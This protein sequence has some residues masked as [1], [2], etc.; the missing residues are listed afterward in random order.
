MNFKL[1]PWKIIISLAVGFIFFV[2][3]AGGLKCDSPNG[4]PQ[5]TYNSLVWGIAIAILIYIVFSLF[6]KFKK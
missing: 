4:C 2:Y 5:A 6:Q 1:I 3:D